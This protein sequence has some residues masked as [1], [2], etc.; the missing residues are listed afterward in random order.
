MSYAEYLAAEAGSDVRHEFLDGRVCAIAGGTPEHG[1]LTLASVPSSA[2][3][4][5]GNR[6][7]LLL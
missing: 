3:R 6:A 1:A 2:T 7:V 5:V 4:S